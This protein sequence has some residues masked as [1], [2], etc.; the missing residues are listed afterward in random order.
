[1]VRGGLQTGMVMAGPIAYSR[2]SLAAS[3]WLDRDKSVAR[4][5]PPRWAFRGL[6]A[7]LD[8]VGAVQLGVVVWLTDLNVGVTELAPMV[9]QAGLES[10]FLTEHTHIPVSRRDV[11]SDQEH[12]QDARILDQFTALGAAAA[13]TSRLKLG[14]GM[15][16]V[17]QAGAGSASAGAGR[18]KRAA[19]PAGGSRMRRWMDADRR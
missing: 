3:D 6:L 14:T 8:G 10:L 4:A 16:L 11:L 19:D 2:R 17:A 15:C 18:R 9:E 13:V 12:S 5:G 7:R 1:M